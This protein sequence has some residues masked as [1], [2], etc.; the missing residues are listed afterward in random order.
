MDINLLLQYLADKNTYRLDYSSQNVDTS[1][2]IMPQQYLSY[3]KKDLESGYEHLYINALSNMNRALICQINRLLKL[4]GYY[5]QS[6]EEI[7]S[8]VKKVHLIQKFGI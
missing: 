7:W 1:F 2:S 8:F 5:N 6:R 3:A 4:I